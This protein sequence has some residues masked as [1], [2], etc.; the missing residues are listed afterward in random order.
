MSIMIP[1]TLELIKC[2]SL[3]R[4][5]HNQICCYLI[6]YKPYGRPIDTFIAGLWWLLDQKADSVCQWPISANK[7]SSRNIAPV[8]FWHDFCCW[9][10]TREN[11]NFL[12]KPHYYNTYYLQFVTFISILFKMHACMQYIRPLMYQLHVGRRGV[13]V[14]LQCMRTIELTILLWI[15]LFTY[16]MMI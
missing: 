9:Q 2:T 13:C 16:F 5:T 10:V 4:F 3:K 15:Y 12:L 11:G 7:T 6:G 1:I 14:Y 8:G